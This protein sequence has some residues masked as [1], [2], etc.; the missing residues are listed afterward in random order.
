MQGPSIPLTFF[1]GCKK[2]LLSCRGFSVHFDWAWVSSLLIEFYLF[3]REQK[4]YCLT[5][6]APPPCS[7]EEGERPGATSRRAS[8]QA[9][10]NKLQ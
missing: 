3:R 4:K 10:V 8:F 2:M 9:C 1:P 5:G 7:P 6:P